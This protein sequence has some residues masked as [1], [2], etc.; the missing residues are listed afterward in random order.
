MNLELTADQIALREATRDFLTRQPDFDIRESTAKPQR[1]W[2]ISTWEALGDLGVQGLC[3]PTQFGGSGL[4]PV[5][6]VMIAE[7]LGRALA[8]EPVVECAMVPAE[9]LCRA[10]GEEQCER[11][12]P[13]IASGDVLAVIARPDGPYSVPTINA[14]RESDEFF[15]SGTAPLVRNAQSVNLLVVPAVLDDKVSFLLVDPIQPGV[16]RTAYLSHDQSQGATICFDR[17]IAELMPAGSDEVLRTVVAFHQTALC[18]EAVG[19]MDTALKT[20][21][22]YLQQRRQF[23]SLLADFQALSHRAAEMYVSVELAR[24]ITRYA[25]VVIGLDSIDADE[26]LASRSAV[27]VCRAIRQI[28]ETCIHMHGGIGVTEEHPI[29]RLAARLIA[30]EQQLGGIDYH[31]DVLADSVK[32]DRSPAISDVELAL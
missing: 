24:S 22:E 30:I 25:S 21:V 5:E 8:P 12:L 1:R 3:M 2:R 16:Q 27:Q 10:A 28:A 4:G 14:W 15:V 17:A 31:L 7:E 19:V 32:P 20:T 18:S 13:S 29:G 6:A 23:G 11:L 9:A 26:H